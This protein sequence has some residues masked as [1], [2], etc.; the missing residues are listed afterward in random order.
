MAR[1][2][3]LRK[4]RVLGYSF[5]LSPG[6]P[7]APPDADQLASFARLIDKQG[8]NVVTGGQAAFVRLSADT[9]RARAFG[10]LPP[11]LAVLELSEDVVA[12][13]DTRDACLEAKKGG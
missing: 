9:L 5:H 1:E 3:I 8:P 4:N 11:S 6:A 13:E 10:S 2:P 7:G 12:D